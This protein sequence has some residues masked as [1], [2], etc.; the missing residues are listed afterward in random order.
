M[1]KKKPVA[2]RATQRPR[3]AR[4][5][6][7]RDVVARVTTEAICQRAYHLFLAHGATHGHDVEDWLVA[8]AELL[9]E[10]SP[11]TASSWSRP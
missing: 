11:D 5:A 1:V 8:E 6:A 7:K 3:A 2:P 10:S 9:K 4:S